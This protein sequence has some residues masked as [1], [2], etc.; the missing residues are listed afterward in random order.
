MTVLT[1]SKSLTKEITMDNKDLELW[2]YPH[3]NRLAKMWEMNDG[4][5]KGRVPILVEDAWNF[6]QKRIYELKLMLVSASL[7]LKNEHPEV[8]RLLDKIVN[9]EVSDILNDEQNANDTLKT[10]ADNVMLILSE[11][12]PELIDMDNGE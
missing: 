8:A 5:W 2:F 9:T 7:L 6:Q 11:F 10:K 12:A 1:F 4:E 3:A